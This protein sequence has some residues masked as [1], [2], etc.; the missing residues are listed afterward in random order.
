MKAW[1]GGMWGGEGDLFQACGSYLCVK[2]IDIKVLVLI[3]ELC[4]NVKIH[5]D[6]LRLIYQTVMA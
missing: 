4:N 5:T 2:W 1:G 3:P 6:I